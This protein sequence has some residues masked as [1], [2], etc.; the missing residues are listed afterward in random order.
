MRSLLLA[1]L[2][3]F[4]TIC[5]ASDSIDEI[6]NTLDSH[7]LWTNGMFQPIMLSVSA[8]PKQVATEYLNRAHLDKSNIIEIRDVTISS[9]KYYAVLIDSSLGEKVVILQYQG[10][11]SGWWSKEFSVDNLTHR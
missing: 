8:S 10:L 1:T 4:C 6:I 9:M 7:G 2:L 5:S 11:K 3:L